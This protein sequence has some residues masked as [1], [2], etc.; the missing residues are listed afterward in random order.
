MEEG[1]ESE[2]RYTSSFLPSVDKIYS[3]LEKEALAIIFGVKKFHPYLYDR[4]FMIYTDHQPLMHLFNDSR[5][6]PLMASSCIQ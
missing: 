6:I 3:Q 2:I 5:P 1:S 4:S